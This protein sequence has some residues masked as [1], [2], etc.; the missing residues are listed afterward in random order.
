MAGLQIHGRGHSHLQ[1]VLLAVLIAL[2]VLLL[3][4]DR[5]VLSQLAG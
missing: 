5:T 1:L 4:G 3:A 2:V